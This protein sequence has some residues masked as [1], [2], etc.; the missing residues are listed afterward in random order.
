MVIIEQENWEVVGA[1][2]TAQKEKLFLEV[3]QNLWQLEN[4]AE[5]YYSCIS[6]LSNAKN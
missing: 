6:M 2:E 4:H 3:P 5:K 1:E